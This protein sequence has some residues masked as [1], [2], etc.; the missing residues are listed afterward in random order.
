MK[1][2]SLDA[3]VVVV[4]V[5]L[6]TITDNFT[7]RGYLSSLVFTTSTMILSTSSNGKSFV[8]NEVGD[9]RITFEEPVEATIK[10]TSTFATFDEGSFTSRTTA[11]PLGS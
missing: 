5:S 11:P 2:Y 4:G 7:R 9:P 6:Q 10:V 8:A 3:F 1:S